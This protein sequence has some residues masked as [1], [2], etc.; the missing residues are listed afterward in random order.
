MLRE[1]ILKE[2][3]EPEKQY[4]LSI[5]EE[6]RKKIA[7]K[8]DKHGLIATGKTVVDHP[9]EVLTP[10]DNVKEFL[11]KGLSIA[12]NIPEIEF[13][14]IP[15]K[16]R[17]F[18]T[19]RIKDNSIWSSWN[20]AGYDV[21]SE[22]FF[23]AV[24]DHGWKN[25]HLHLVE[26]DISEKKLTCLPEIN[27]VLGRK[28]N[29][30]GDGKIHGYL[31]VYKPS[32]SDNR[33]L[34]FCTYWCRYPE[35][36]DSDFESGYNGGHI[37]SWDLERKCFIDYGVPLERA[38]WPFHRVDRKRGILY[39]IGMFSEFLAWDIDQQKIKW[40]GFLPPVGKEKDIYAV[41]PG[42]KWYNRCMLLD[43]HT[44]S[45]YSNNLLSERWSIIEYN[46]HKNRF[47]EL[48]MDTK[49][50]S[51]MRCHT[52]ERDKEGYFWGLTS[53]GK[54]FSFNPDK[55]EFNLFNK[56]WPMVD[57]YSV[58]MDSS[59]GGRYLYFGIAS[60]ARG[61]AYG[62]PVLQY[63]KKT[64]KTKILCFLFPYYYQKYGYVPGGSYS[65]KLN[66]TGDKLFM[67][68]NGKFTE[69]NDLYEKMKKYDIENPANWSIPQEHDAFGD[70]SIFVIN[71]PKE[72]REE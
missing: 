62:S 63:D 39:A 42:M 36:L 55:P 41:S 68:W 12:K 52:R 66:N 23:G 59:P 70:C 29:Q 1:R 31:D 6:E 22:K 53:D 71:I 10:P 9:Q 34:W 67:L 21:R 30:F 26:Y 56:L 44:G 49:L 13:A 65:F 7:T 32:F 46:P 2:V 51:P 69:I 33:Q 38:S 17:Y 61:Y 4:A 19:D 57:N 50:T 54:L 16:Y 58:S 40:A 64:A 5:E 60:H 28:T 25:P 47:Y 72:E 48:D 11:G 18:G 24:G 15:Y 14:V 20:Q 8:K 35:P 43:E 3:D 27:R 37:M 45:L